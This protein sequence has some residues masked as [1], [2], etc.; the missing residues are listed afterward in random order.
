[1]NAV[2]AIRTADSGRL[3]LTILMPC[4]NEAETLATC[5]GKAQR[6]L[7]RA[8]IAGGG[9]DR[10]QRLH[11]GSQRSRAGSGARVVPVAQKG[12]GAARL[13]GSATRPVRFRHHGRR[14]DS[15][16]FSALD[17]F[18]ARLRD[19]AELV[20]GNRFRGGIE[21]GAM[22]VLH[23]YLG[24]PVL[25][26]L[27][28][29][30]FRIGTGDFHCGLRG[31]NAEAIRG[32]DL[33]TTGMEFA[34]EM[35]VRGALAGLRIEEVPTTLKPDGRSRPPH[36]R[37]WR[38]ALAA[39]EIPADVQ[40]A[41]AVLHSRRDIGRARHIVCGAAAVRPAGGG[42][43]HL[44]RPQHLHGRLFHDRGRGAAPHLRGDLAQLCRDDRDPA[45]QCAFPLAGPDG[46]HRQAGGKCGDLL[47][48]RPMFFG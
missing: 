16:D 35:V 33:Q 40:S 34:S 24:N 17:A 8:G 47:R 37:T 5:I 22:P 4:L 45:G 10:R 1:M 2:T 26:Y 18:V 21:A 29:L 38:D 12:F 14:A 11:R 43:Q 3:E 7:E 31:F 46:Q 36:L 6:F 15:Y 9:A 39:P 41:L 27:G 44:A 30:F 20:M 13:G 25:S 23:R 42:Q 19:G 28:R 32:L 48:R